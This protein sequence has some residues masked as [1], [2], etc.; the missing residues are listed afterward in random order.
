MITLI[1]AYY[2]NPTM[3]AEQFKV[4]KSYPKQIKDKISLIVVDDCSPKS[5][6]LDHWQDPGFPASLYRITVDIPWN[7]IAAKN[8]AAHKSE[9]KWL[10]LTDM[11]HVVPA[12]TLA[13]CLRG[14]SQSKV[15][16]FRRL[17]APNMQEVPP[18]PNSWL[19]TRDLFH[20]MG[21]Y[22]ERFSGHYGSDSDFKYRAMDVADIK[23]LPCPLIRFGRSL[24][25]DSATTRYKRKQPE[26]KQAVKDIKRLRARDRNWRPLNL[27]FPWERLV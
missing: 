16:Q 5:P 9:S 27:T 14:H 15:Y 18:H 12:D 26:D 10:L 6:A 4:W 11:D 8:L 21:G 2:D 19:I 24:I 3:L 17:D 22:D 1:Y 13:E 20:R 25:P 23:V 7:W